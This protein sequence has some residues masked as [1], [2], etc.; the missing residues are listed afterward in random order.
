LILVA[1]VNRPAAARADLRSVAAGPCA[2][3]PKRLLIGA[4]NFVPEFAGRPQNLQT[5]ASPLR[6]VITPYLTQSAAVEETF[7]AS[8]ELFHLTL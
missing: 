4:R 2:R 1:A 8:E 3:R 6:N 7:L 5:P